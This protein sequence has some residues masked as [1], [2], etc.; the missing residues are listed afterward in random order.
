VLKPFIKRDTGIQPLKVKLLQEITLDD[1]IVEFLT[2]PA[3]ELLG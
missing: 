3:Y 1:E 2:L